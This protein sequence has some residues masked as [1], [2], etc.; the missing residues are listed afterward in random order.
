MFIDVRTGGTS[1]QDPDNFRELAVRV[2][3]AMDPYARAQALAALGPRIDDEHLS[4][5]PTTLARLAGPHGKEPT[6]QSGFDAMLE[7]ARSHGWVSD[8]GAVRVHVETQA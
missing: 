5:E 7:Y 6:W 4:I 3:T 1:L 2:S 8:S